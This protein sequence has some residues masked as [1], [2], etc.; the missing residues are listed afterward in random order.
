[1]KILI[2]AMGGDN[3][4]DEIIKGCVEAIDELE[5]EIILVGNEQIINEKVKEFYGKDSISE[6]SERLSIKNATEVITNEE[7]P[8]EAIK[9]KKDSSMVVAF[10][11]LKEGE[12]GV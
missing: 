6:V 10:K 5:S 8:T 7:S 4:P 12:D 2:D 9:R 11:M 3:S 1:M